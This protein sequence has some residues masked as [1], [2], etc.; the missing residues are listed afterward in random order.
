MQS[1]RTY[2]RVS[3]K[4][5]V[6]IL[7]G[8]L[9]VISAAVAEE[10]INE[11]IPFAILSQ[12]KNSIIKN[13]QHQHYEEVAW[14]PADNKKAVE[15]ILKTAEL[16]GGESNFK[17]PVIAT[18]DGGMR[19]L[20]ENKE[21]LASKIVFGHAQKL[22][23]GG[24]DKVELFDYLIKNTSS[25]IVPISVSVSSPEDALTAFRKINKN[26]IIK[27]SIKPISMDMAGMKGK[28]IEL[29]LH[30]D[31]NSIVEKLKSYWMV[32]ECWIVQE[33]LETPVSGEYDIWFSRNKLGEIIALAATERWKQPRVGG[34]G[35]WVESLGPVKPE[36]LDE[37]K[38]I[39]EAIDFVG[40][41]EIPFLMDSSGG[42]KMIELNCRPWLQVGLGKIAGVNFVAGLYSALTQQA[43]PVSQPL[44]GKIWVN[45]ER[46][47][48]SSLTNDYASKAKAFA[49]LLKI[50]KDAD[51]VA[52][53]SS[54][55]KNIR[56]N[57]LK[58]LFS[59]SLR[60][61]F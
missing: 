7:S 50:L 29:Q 23:Y 8:G 43:M 31:D 16:M 22:I 34:T 40:S 61:L 53:W 17:I 21:R 1:E 27:P 32:S 55:I 60:N 30:N 14:P 54:P 28:A 5:P 44:A 47:I 46:A 56:L 49:T 33:K 51:E 10:L 26:C 41:G 20:M 57:W 42:Y 36:L 4:T 37:V 25:K 38:S 58:K 12:V 52:V 35:C 9:E 2:R 45:L 18:E 59:K 6:I 39:L 13:C 48:I 24:L 11:E 15:Q 19:F 3:M